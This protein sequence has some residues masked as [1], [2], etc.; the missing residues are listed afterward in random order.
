MCGITGFIQN[1]SFSKADAENT[2]ESMTEKLIHRGPDSCG[3]WIS[4]NSQVALGFSIDYTTNRAE[5]GRESK[6]NEV[7][8]P[9]QPVIVP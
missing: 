1:A 6:K 2:I 4:D 5:V 7:A 3:N 8:F 9:N